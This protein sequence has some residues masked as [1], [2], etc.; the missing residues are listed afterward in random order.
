MRFTFA[1]TTFPAQR[2][3]VSGLIDRPRWSIGLLV[4]LAATGICGC[5]GP[6]PKYFPPAPIAVERLPDGGED[7]RYDVSGDGC[8]DYCERRSPDGRVILLRFD[9]NADG[10]YAEEV[11]RLLTQEASS[12]RGDRHLVIIL[13]SIPWHMVQEFWQQGRFRYFPPPSRLISPFPVMTDLSLSEF[14]G[15]SP[16][17]GVESEYYDG[18]VLRDGYDIYAHEGNAAW[19]VNVDYYLQ[20]IAHA[21]A[22]LAP[23]RWFE[24][25]MG[26]IQRHFYGSEKDFFVGYVVSTSGLGAW[27]GRDGHQAALVRLDRFCQHVMHTLRGR[28]Q[29][30]LLSD[31][32]HNLVNSRRVPLSEMLRRIGYRVTK[33]LSGPS[34]VVVP[35]FGVVTCAAIYTQRAPDVARDVLGI[36]GIEHTAYVDEV[37]DVIVQSRDGLARIRARHEETTVPEESNGERRRPASLRYD[38]ERGDPFELLSIIDDLRGRGLVDADGFIVDRV[39]FEATR[40]HKYPDAVY[41]IWRSFHG[42]MIYTPDVMVSVQ[43]GWHCGSPFMSWLCDLQAAHGNL[44][45]LSSY[46]FVMT[47]MGELP[48]IVRMEDLRE[49]LRRLGVPFASDR[50]EEGSVVSGVSPAGSL[51]PSLGD[52]IVEQH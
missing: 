52:G 19:T 12:N 8:L 48:D 49:E 17:P 27:E 37:G 21:V 3:D 47:T 10:E 18:T 9:A 43:D 44:G 45:Q 31:H 11:E 15:I 32:G 28:V 20:F 41:R 16:S 39:L 23:D 46:G 30:T 2:A 34:D 4:W 24:H 13:D 40:A 14:Y 42:L 6:A 35:E 50:M 7:W 38:C 51:A 36:D 33:R 25:E 1:L 29:L 5:A 22:Y 26:K